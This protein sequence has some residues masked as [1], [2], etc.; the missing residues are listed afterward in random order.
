MNSNLFQD[1][2][3]FFVGFRF[4]PRCPSVSRDSRDSRMFL[5]FLLGFSSDERDS[6][7]F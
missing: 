5:R 2:L 1:S 4:L 7:A 3:G 6:L